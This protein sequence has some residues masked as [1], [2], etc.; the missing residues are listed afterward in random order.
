MIGTRTGA[1]EHGALRPFSPIR[2]DLRPGL[3]SQVNQL[4]MMSSIEYLLD[5]SVVAAR[6][7]VARACAQEELPTFS[8]IQLENP[9]SGFGRCV[10]IAPSAGPP[11]APECRRPLPPTAAPR[12]VTTAPSP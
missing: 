7:R 4:E 12:N 3:D 5:A 8:R 2:F 9:T 1:P 6:R 10:N 11:G